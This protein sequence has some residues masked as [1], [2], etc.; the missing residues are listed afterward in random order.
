MWDGH[1]NVLVVEPYY[2]SNT[3]SNDPELHE[4]QIYLQNLFDY[5]DGESTNNVP[6]YLKDFPFESTWKNRRGN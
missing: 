4:L 2:G 6:R 3:E 5:V 1:G